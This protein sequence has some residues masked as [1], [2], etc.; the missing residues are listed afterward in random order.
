MYQYYLHGNGAHL[1]LSDM[2]LKDAVFNALNSP[3]D[4]N[5]EQGGEYWRGVYLPYSAGQGG[6]PTGFI[7]HLEKTV[8]DMGLELIDKS[9]SS[10]CIFFNYDHTWGF[11]FS[12]IAWAMGGGNIRTTM[13]Y[14]SVSW[15]NGYDGYIY[16]DI[17]GEYN[18]HYYD[19]FQQPLNFPYLEWG[20][21][22]T[23]SDGWLYQDVGWGGRIP[24]E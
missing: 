13:S 11:N 17:G 5:W 24:F 1:Y 6:N 16:Y 7:S 21:S 23:Y 2:G 20:T 4:E 14:F 10:G 19:T 12:P 22:Y 9:Q 3:Y 8:L 15:H 18:L